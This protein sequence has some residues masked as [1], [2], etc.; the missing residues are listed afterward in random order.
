MMVNQNSCCSVWQIRIIFAIISSNKAKGKIEGR[1]I[2][3]DPIVL[4]SLST[5]FP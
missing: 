4:S 1:A 5:G 3:K 2:W